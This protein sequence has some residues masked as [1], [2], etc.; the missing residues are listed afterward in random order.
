VTATQTGLYCI[1]LV[2]SENCKI[3]ENAMLHSSGNDKAVKLPRKL[4]EAVKVLIW[5]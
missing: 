4:T 5:V 3:N 2:D 1:K